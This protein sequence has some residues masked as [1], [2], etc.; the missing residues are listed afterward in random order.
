LRL[1]EKHAFIVTSNTPTIL[2]VEVHQPSIALFIVQE[3]GKAMNDVLAH[4][5]QSAGLQRILAAKDSPPSRVGALGA[6]HKYG[7]IDGV[8]C[9]V[10]K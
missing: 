5:C 8:E 2:M 6:I 10:C 4:E 1:L 3:N 9:I 7:K